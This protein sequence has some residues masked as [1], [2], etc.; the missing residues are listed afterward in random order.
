M[1]NSVIGLQLL[2]WP[3][4]A[5]WESQLP[6]TWRNL[7]NPIHKQNWTHRSLSSWDELTVKFICFLW[8][9]PC[10][11]SV[12]GVVENPPGPLVLEDPSCCCCC[13]PQ[14]ARVTWKYLGNNWSVMG[15]ETAWSKL[16][17]SYVFVHPSLLKQMQ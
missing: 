2:V 11:V 4:C 16:S 10:C 12:F 5:C 9:I 1:L 14:G 15:A 17:I 3:P 7:L 6:Y 13:R 8:S